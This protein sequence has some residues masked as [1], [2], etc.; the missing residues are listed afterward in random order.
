MN[1]VMEVRA[2]GH[3]MHAQAKLIGKRAYLKMKIV[4]FLSHAVAL[5]QSAQS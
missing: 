3:A 5:F 1:A 4:G 2:F